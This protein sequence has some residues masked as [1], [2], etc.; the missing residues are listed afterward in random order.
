MKRLCLT[1]SS[2][3]RRSGQGVAHRPGSATGRARR[4][5][6]MRTRGCSRRNSR[7]LLARAVQVA[8]VATRADA[9]QP[10]AR[11]GAERPR[12]RDPGQRLRS[13]GV[14]ASLACAG[15]SMRS[16][17][18]AV[19]F[20]AAAVAALA[21]AASLRGARV[22]DVRPSA[23][24]ALGEA[25]SR[26]CAPD[27]PLRRRRRAV[28]ARGR[29]LGRPGRIAGARRI[30]GA[31]FLHDGCRRGGHCAAA[32]AAT[33]VVGGCA[34]ACCGC[35]ADRDEALGCGAAGARGVPAVPAEA[36]GTAEDWRRGA[37]GAARPARR[38][39]DLP[40]RRS[41]CRRLRRAA[42][43]PAGRGRNCQ[44]TP[45]A[46]TSAG[47]HARAGDQAGGTPCQRQPA[48]RGGLRAADGR[49]RG[50]ED[51]RVQRRRRARRAD[52][53]RAR[54]SASSRSSA[55]AVRRRVVGA[56]HSLNLARSLSIA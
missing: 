41:R 26:A 4:S 13:S 15:A 45:T 46:S 35:G 55:S 30:D 32:P 16:S 7:R 6:G 51:L 21:A 25:G 1:S 3:R 19:D 11:S 36:S 37:R 34:A 27:S 52:R 2:V 39:D 33:S 44:T 29:V 40:R 23:R 56:I 18:G 31:A 22:R 28:G 10:V 38:V 48:A 5:S 42:R 20:A 12:A 47:G 8:V 17:G 24:A 49:V 53:S 9:L 50:G 54:R 14:A 43:E